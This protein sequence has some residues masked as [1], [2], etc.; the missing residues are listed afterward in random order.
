VIGKDFKGKFAQEGRLYVWVVPWDGNKKTAGIYSVHVASGPNLA[1]GAKRLEAANPDIDKILEPKRM[2][3]EK[4]I[5]E[6]TAWTDYMRKNVDLFTPGF[7]R[8]DANKKAQYEKGI[9]NNRQEIEDL[10]K[11]IRDEIGLHPARWLDLPRVE[12]VP[13]RGF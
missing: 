4:L 5:A 13:W 10:N 9:Q 7:P 1:P 8:F 6:L 3:R 11:E 12:I 2:K